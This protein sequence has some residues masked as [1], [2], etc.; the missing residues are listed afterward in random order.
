MDGLSR[1]YAGLL[2]GS[3]DCVD[4]IVLNGFFSMGHTAGGLRTGW[5]A[6]TGP[7]GTLNNAHL[8]RMAG[9]FGRRVHA[10][11]A[12]NQ[13]PIKNCATVERNQEIGEEHL[14]S[15]QLRKGSFLSWS[16]AH[17]HRSGTFRKEDTSAARIQV[18][19]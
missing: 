8:M 19:S 15:T 13:I 16:A 6:L 17:R 4:R 5:R 9:R 7:D 18:R 14:A 3:Y 10:W 12:E 11:A 2:T 1:T